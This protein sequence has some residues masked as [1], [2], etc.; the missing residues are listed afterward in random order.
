M[1]KL[2]TFSFIA[3][4]SIA[5]SSA[6]GASTWVE[7]SNEHAEVVLDLIAKLGPE[8]AGRLGVDGLDEQI[9]DL[10][11]GIEER[12]RAMNVAVVAELKQRLA[13]ETDSKVRQDLGI[14]I[15]SM[16]D[17]IRSSDLNYEQMLP[18]FNISQAIFLVNARFARCSG[19]LSL[20]HTRSEQ[21]L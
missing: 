10:G 21:P 11:P 5:L 6:A 20:S 9:M 7:K 4:F 17:G 2:S 8:G 16:E 13:D 19:V 14:L 12:S 15:K 1:R 3:A 18:Y